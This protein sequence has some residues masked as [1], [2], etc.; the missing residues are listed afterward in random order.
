MAQSSVT[1]WGV[2]DA[3]YSNYS[4]GGVSKAF[5]TTSGNASSQLGFKGT[6]DLGG[7][8]SASFWLEAGMTVDN[9]TAGNLAF[10]RRS[11][12]D[13]AGS[14]GAIRLGRDYTP[15]FWNH[16]V[17]DPFGTLGAGAGS[18]ITLPSFG[19]N[20]LTAARTNN[21]ISYL[22]NV[23]AN[24]G[25]H[26]LGSQGVYAQVTY[27]LAEN[28]SNAATGAAGQ[29]QGVRVG[30]AAGPMN[31]AASYSESNN[32]AT[33][34]TKYKET[35]FAGSYDMGVAQLM[36]H[37][38]TNDTTTAAGNK[39]T[40]M[41]IGAKIPMGN[42]YIPVS[43]NVTETNNAKATGAS[44]FAIGYVYNFSKRTALYT[45]YSA[46]TNKNGGAYTFLGGNGG[47]N[48][49]FTGL[50]NVAGQNGTGYDIGLRHSF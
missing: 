34:A 13:L 39:Q 4:Q 43:Y 29:Y 6:E 21:G 19:T 17:F 12:I 32:S 22:Y 5:M 26:A 28:L 24:G 10:Q 37:W 33:A 41:G 35:N 15:S 20:A 45:A 16:T 14:F 47:G 48:P 27:A 23:A 18:N 1:I 3:A 38:G 31:F 36:A 30:Y 46:L 49:G 25:S 42:G 44:Q 7:G 9:G 11:T 40:H 8:M 50:S 2:V